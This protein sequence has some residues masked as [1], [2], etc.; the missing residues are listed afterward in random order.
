MATPI[1]VPRRAGDPH[2][3]ELWRWLR[4]HLERDLPDFPIV[5]GHDD[6]GAF[7]RSAALNR[8]AR[9]APPWTEAIVL[10]ADTYVRPEQLRRAVTV[11]RSSGRLTYAFDELHALTAAGTEQVLGG[12]R[13]S[14]EPLKKWTRPGRLCAS[15]A[16][17]V[18]RALWDDV[19]GFDEL[20][21]GWG[22]E[23]VAF[24]RMA[25][26]LGGH[27]LEVPGPAWHLWHPRSAHKSESDPLMA[28]ARARGERYKRGDA[29]ELDLLRSESV[30]A[31]AR[32]VVVLMANGRRSYLERTLPGLYRLLE[33]ELVERLIVHDDSADRDFR[34]WLLEEL[35]RHS[36]ITPELV[37]TDRAGY[38][39]AMASAWAAARSTG[40]PLVF[41]LEEDFLLDDVPLE[42]MA[43][44]LEARPELAQVVLKRQAWYRGEVKAGGMIER[45]PGRWADVDEPYPH[46]EHRIFF[47]VNPTLF[48][49]ELLDRP[50]PKT[51]GSEATFGRELLFDEPHRKFA[52]WGS[53]SS[54]PAVEHI[55]K[56]RAGHGY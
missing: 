5:E 43:E 11:A 2:R 14:W 40:L 16:F 44:L 47:S 49:S 46:V 4:S 31:R 18:P 9:S 36:R 28:A 51:A 42:Q 41:W 33:H 20:F 35:D 54:P 53:S 56:E 24:R 21:E 17:V 10:D 6:V 37:T 19:G 22:W 26:T 3:D 27:E 50:W 32:T 7:N 34:R 39:G 52:L 55:G 45:F 29:L 13:R 23:D 15:S 30:R 48:R 12:Y 8:A 38:G 1:L 25:T